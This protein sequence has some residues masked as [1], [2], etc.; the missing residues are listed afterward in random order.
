MQRE[1]EFFWGDSK[2]LW[3]DTPAR[4]LPTRLFMAA[5]EPETEL[6]WLY[7]VQAF[8]RLIAHR[9]YSDFSYEFHTIAGVHHG[10]VKFPTFARGLAFIFKQYIANGSTGQH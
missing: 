5:G 4:N 6:N 2:E 7:E 10:G 3:K 1:I 9:K 8:D